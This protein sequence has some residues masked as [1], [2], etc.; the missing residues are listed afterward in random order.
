MGANVVCNR[1]VE[2]NTSFLREWGVFAIRNLCEGN[3]ENQ[4]AIAQLRIQGVA[5]N[6]LLEK[7]G[8]QVELTKDGAPK[9]VKRKP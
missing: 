5:D 2:G 6:K 8:L 3:E 1:H 7:A 4:Q 9:V